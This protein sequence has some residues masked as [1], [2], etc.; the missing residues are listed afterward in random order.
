MRLNPKQIAQA[1]G[2]QFLVEPIDGAEVITSVTLDSRE[3]APGALYVAIVGERVDG[4]AYVEAAL[5]AGARAA[6]VSEPVPEPCKILAR[7]LGAAIIMVSNTEHAVA[8]IAAEWRRHL[9]AKVIAVTGSVGKTT[10]KNLIRD[11]CASRFQTCA[12][13]GNQ[14]NELGGPLTLLSAD[15][16]DEV[17]VME[18]G[19]DGPG[20]IRFLAR[21]AR[22]DWGV[23]TNIGTSHMEFLGSQE[24]IA[25]A[26]AEL[27]EELPN[28][29]GR[30]F[31][32]EADPFTP[33]LAECGKL[34]ER[35]IPVCLYGGASTL[36]ED[37]HRC[38]SDLDA[39]PTPGDSMPTEVAHAQ[40]VWA[41]N[42][43]SD[44]E[45]RPQFD[46]CWR[47]FREEPSE[48]PTLFD[49]EPD[50]ERASVKLSLRGAHNVANALAAA[51]VGRALNIDPETIARALSGSV[52]EAG[53]QEM[54]RGRDGFLI[55]NDAYNAS[56][57]SMRASLSLLASMDVA[58]R[59]IAV[60]G[61]M[62]EL[63]ELSEACHEGVGRAA[64]QAG[65]DAL[66]CVGSASRKIA[67]GAQ[68]AGMASERIRCVDSIG[69]ALEAL[70]DSLEP[71][72]VV[73]VKASHFMGLSRLAEGLA[74]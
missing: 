38:A 31:L 46:I 15:P 74:S 41:E 24:N 8:D 60:L 61:D 44:A 69:G 25:R 18:M 34:E 32:P 67:E 66:I 28:G 27:L 40:S 71:E 52:P 63:G 45:G 2:G 23:V 29:S 64:A 11:V 72:D 37:G 12:T 56:P 5:N 65:L 1:S 3:T 51:G 62:G 16:T 47:G 53:R 6:I 30:A 10:T 59:R 70:E 26:K 55:I 20:Q 43:S 21:M 58:G 19:M 33:F 14:N 49:M 7:E 22:P 35:R 36:E 42:V 4:H 68:G 50:T 9:N 13:R 48:G 39:H 57:D 54:L 73:L 17:V